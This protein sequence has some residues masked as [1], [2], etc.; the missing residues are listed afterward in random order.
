MKCIWNPSTRS[1]NIYM[2]N[3]SRF[4][5]CGS[6]NQNSYFFFLVAQIGFSSL[7]IDWLGQGLQRAGF[8]GTRWKIRTYENLV[9]RLGKSHLITMCPTTLSLSDPGDVI[10]GI[11]GSCSSEPEGGPFRK[12]NSGSTTKRGH[13]M[14]RS[15]IT[16][17]WWFSHGYLM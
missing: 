3:A 2:L 5:S 13:S 17:W 6:R 4:P 11:I 14:W 8:K 9:E 16:V 15:L 10:V 12:A 1:Y 7:C